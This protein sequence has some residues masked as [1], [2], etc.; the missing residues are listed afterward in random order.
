MS[1]IFHGTSLGNGHVTKRGFSTTNLRARLAS[2]EAP[3][4]VSR[5]GYLR[6]NMPSVYQE[7]DFGLR[8]LESLEMSLDP[9]VATLD[10]LSRYFH[11]TLAPRDVLGLLASWVGLPVDESWAD[12]R[13]RE[14]LSRESEISRRRGTKAGLEMA[15]EIAFPQLPLR[16]EDGGGVSWSTDPNQKTKAPP[17]AFVVYCDTPIQEKIQLAVSRV[18]EETKP[19]HVTYKLRVKAAKKPPS[20]QPPK[21]PPAAGS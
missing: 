21:E 18:I 10:V 17:P 15:L 5:R 20:Q 8:F 13:L 6:T 9:I 19:V 1:T 3:A 11:S 7:G 16:V 2:T 12:D 14:A 4:V